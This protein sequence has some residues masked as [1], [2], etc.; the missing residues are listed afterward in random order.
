MKIADC[1]SVQSMDQTKAENQRKIRT[2]SES[3]TTTAD[4]ISFISQKK[5]EILDKVT[6]GDTQE[7]ISLGGSTFTVQEWERLLKKVDVNVE[8]VKQ[9]QEEKQEKQKEELLENQQL[10]QKEST[11]EI[12]EEQSLKVSDE[13]LENLLL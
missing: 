2:Q 1:G 4:L 10:E 3:E 13:V 8:A 11:S 5:Q 7:A 9:S 12:L 6:T